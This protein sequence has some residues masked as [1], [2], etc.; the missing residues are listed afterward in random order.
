MELGDVIVVV[1]VAEGVSC[2]WSSGLSSAVV[3]LSSP[4]VSS[5]V[6]I[7]SSS[8]SSYSCAKANLEIAMLDG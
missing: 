8:S 1:V 7:S 6:V 5:S 3:S 2:I 4:S